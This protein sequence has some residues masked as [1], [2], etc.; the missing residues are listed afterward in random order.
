MQIIPPVRVKVSC[1][2]T[3]EEARR[4]ESFGAAAI[5]VASRLPFDPEGLSDERIAAIAAAV[6]EDTGTFL[7]TDLEDPDA[8]AAQAIRCGVNTVQLWSALPR[9]AYVEL[10]RAAPE[11]AIAQTIH[12]VDE[13]AIDTARELAGVADALVLGSTNPDPPFRWNAPHG[14][15]HDWEISRR[16]A[17]AAMIPVILSGGLTHRNVADAIRHVRPYGV[18]VCSGVRSGGALDTHLLV[19][20]LE[21]LGRV[22]PS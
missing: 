3:P 15:T 11:L 2:R 21:T 7:L 1:V 12:V 8:I 20:F 19:Q 4:A 17:E 13:G 10:R 14:R 6:G 18:E 5:G 9:D 22:K 16:I